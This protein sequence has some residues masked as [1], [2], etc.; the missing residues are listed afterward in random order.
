[1]CTSPRARRHHPERTA[2]IDWDRTL[3]YGAT[4]GAMASASRAM[5]RHSAEWASTGAGPRAIRARW[6]SQGG[7]WPDRLRRQTDHRRGCATCATWSGLRRAVRVRRRVGGQVVLIQPRAGPN[8]QGPRDYARLR[9][10]LSRKEQPALIHWLGGVFGPPS[11][12]T[13]DTPTSMAR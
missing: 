10:I 6:P 8:R 13:G 11:R 3:A 5:E 7:R 1:V 2:T 12:V 9:P 4:S